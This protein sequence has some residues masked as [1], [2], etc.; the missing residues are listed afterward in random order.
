VP[1][2]T[3]SDGGVGHKPD[4]QKHFFLARNKLVWRFASPYWSP[5]P[6]PWRPDCNIFCVLEVFTL[7]TVRTSEMGGGGSAKQTMLN[8]GGFEKSVFA[9]TSL[10][11]DPYI[12]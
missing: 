5:T 4:V 2:W 6:V 12:L 11:D 3:T 9:R 1:M 10:T 8:R 7:D